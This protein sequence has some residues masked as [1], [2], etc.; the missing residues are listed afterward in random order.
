MGNKNSLKVKLHL[1]ADNSNQEFDNQLIKLINTKKIDV[2]KHNSKIKGNRGSYLECCDQAEKAQDLI[3]FIEDDYLF[4]EHSVN[5]CLL[6]YSRISSLLDSEIILC[7]SDYPFFYDSLY[8][9]SLFIGNKHRWRNVGETLLTFMFSKIVFKK[10]KK[11][12]REVGE[13]INEPFEKPLHSIYKKA[14][15][16]A[17]INSLSYHISR[18][19]PDIDNEWKKL[20]EINYARLLKLKS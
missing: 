5:E 11:E 6:T 10:Y 4:E 15:C 1:I 3:F 7:P 8:K 16:L 17:P 20:W 13:K 9:T 12:I 14:I 2:I 18:S 19:V